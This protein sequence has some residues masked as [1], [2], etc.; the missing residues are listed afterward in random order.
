MVQQSNR[1][2]SAIETGGIVIAILATGI[3]I[4]RSL[5]RNHA[6]PAVDAATTGIQVPTAPMPIAGAATLGKPKAPVAM[7]VY[8]DFQCPYC[9][10]FALETLPQIIKSFVHCGR[11]LLAFRN[12]PIEQ[13]HPHAKAAAL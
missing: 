8:S 2:R 1:F 3:V 12:L 5:A 7:I 10:T 13:I 9:K 6:G 11:V 4:W